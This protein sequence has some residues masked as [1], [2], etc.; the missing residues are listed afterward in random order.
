M[1]PG[2]TQPHEHMS[3]VDLLYRWLAR[4]RGPVAD[5]ILAEALTRAEP[6]YADR[7]AGTLLERKQESAW[8]GLIANYDR[9]GPSIRAQLLANPQLVRAAVSEA[10]GSPD[11]RR[12]C[13]ALSLLHDRPYLALSYV[14]ADALRDPVPEVVELAAKTLQRTAVSVLAAEDRVTPAGRSEVVR[15]LR[16]ALRTFSR[17]GRVEVLETCLWFAKDL[18]SALWEAL[19]EH[20]SRAGQ[21]VEQHL[22]RW[23]DP[24]LAGFLLLALARPAW[25]KA[26]QK[27]LDE[28]HQP[29]EL[30]AVL[31]NSDLLNDAQVRQHLHLLKQPRWFLVA[32]SVLP[33]L[34]P[35]LRAKLPYWICYLGFSDA[36]R[37]RCLDAWQ[38][39]PFP[40][41]HRAAVY[42]L[43]ALNDP[44]ANRILARVAQRDCPM[45]QFAAWYCAGQEACSGWQRELHQQRANQPGAEVGAGTVDEVTP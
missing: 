36:Q 35:A 28:W 30:H 24:R 34:A 45:R 18:E 25:R 4:E 9:L 37:V 29:A 16:E 15:A 2:S 13:C 22:P 23:N 11:H 3:K 12:R 14:V 7:L 32:D 19:A 41:L 8:A 42:A 5:R 38:R 31:R 21:L 33:D 20:G 39:A 26:A 44:E 6:Q 1:R 27:L 40:E 43:A 10:A 17:H